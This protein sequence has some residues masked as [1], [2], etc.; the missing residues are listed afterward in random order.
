MKKFCL[1]HFIAIVL[2]SVFMLSESLAMGLGGY[3]TFGSG[4][5]TWTI[6]TEGSDDN[7]IDTD[8]SG[9]G[10]GFILDTAVAKD[11][12]FNY[13]LG[14]GMEKKEYEIDDGPT[15]KVDNFVIDNDF[16]FGVYRTPNI[17][18][19]L[20]PELKI[21]YGTESIDGLDYSVMSFG[22]GPVIGLNY[23]IGDRFT[24][25]VKSGYLFEGTAGY[26]EEDNGDSVDHTGQDTFFYI[27][28]AI[29]YRLN[30]IF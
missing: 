7:D 16:G 29:I 3:Y 8:D 10:F 24:L 26:G 27:N 15:L 4:S 23:N 30:D 11:K 6:N 9:T 25:G 21:S 28:F 22:V 12:L 2:V 17:R 18:L 5:G 20:G 14:V 19:W 13:R 1:A